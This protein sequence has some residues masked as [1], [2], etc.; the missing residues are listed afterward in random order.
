MK[1]EVR[2]KLLKRKIEERTMTKKWI[3]DEKT[4]ARHQF[5]K[6]IVREGKKYQ[7]IEKYVNKQKRRRKIKSK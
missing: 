4:V 3:K 7:I 5:L 6:G 1:K 2:T